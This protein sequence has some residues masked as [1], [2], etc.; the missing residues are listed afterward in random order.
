[1]TIKILEKH[2]YKIHTATSRNV[3][4]AHAHVDVSDKDIFKQLASSNR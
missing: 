3:F 4:H 2:Y 1:M